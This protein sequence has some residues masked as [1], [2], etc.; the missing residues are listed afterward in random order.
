MLQH[1]AKSL[2]RKLFLKRSNVALEA[3]MQ[4]PES[5]AARQLK[6]FLDRYTLNQLPTGTADGSS[7]DSFDAKPV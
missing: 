2:R 4:Q 3:S 5:K 1:I 6:H 7:S